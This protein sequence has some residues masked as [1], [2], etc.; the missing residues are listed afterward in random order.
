MHFRPSACNPIN[1]GVQRWSKK[2]M[3]LLYGLLKQTHDN[4]EFTQHL[5]AEDS[6]EL[7]ITIYD[8]QFEPVRVQT[9]GQQ[10]EN[11]HKT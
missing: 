2:T 4:H 1:G 9:R 5:V 7:S 6:A 8:E 11:I 10:S 3:F